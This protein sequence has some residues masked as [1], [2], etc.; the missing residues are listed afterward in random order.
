MKEGSL[1]RWIAIVVTVLSAAG[2]SAFAQ[3]GECKSIPSTELSTDFSGKPPA[4]PRVAGQR[5]LGLALPQSFE[6]SEFESLVASYRSRKNQTTRFPVGL[7]LEP[8]QHQWSADIWL[9]S[10]YGELEL[11]ATYRMGSCVRELR[12]HLVGSERVD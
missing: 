3:S 8:S 9:P 4:S 2:P 5:W 11:I 10:D 6:G 12:A 1:P 7:H